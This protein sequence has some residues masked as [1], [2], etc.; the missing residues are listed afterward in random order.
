MSRNL[1]RTDILLPRLISFV[2]VERRIIF[3]LD[4][5]MVIFPQCGL[6][7]D[8]NDEPPIEKPNMIVNH[9]LQS[10]QL[11]TSVLVECIYW[12]VYE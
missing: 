2:T 9:S 1:S 12:L 4:D 6:D 11:E 10:D 5:G 3:I 7:V 8:R